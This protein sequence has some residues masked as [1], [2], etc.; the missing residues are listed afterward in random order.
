[1]TPTLDTLT[2]SRMIAE[3]I[4]PNKNRTWWRA[5]HTYEKGENKVTIDGYTCI[6]PDIFS[7]D[8]ED[9]EARNAAMDLLAA[10][11]KPYEIH[12]NQMQACCIIRVD[13]G[14]IVVRCRPSIQAAIAS[15]LWE[16]LE[17]GEEE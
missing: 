17:L 14:L 6:L 4:D 8:P 1:M 11:G 12:D 3:K 13:V 7:T 16:A 15:A 5:N 10:F 9:H 2:K